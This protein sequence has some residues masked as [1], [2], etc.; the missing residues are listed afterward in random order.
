MHETPFQALSADDRY[1]LLKTAGDSA[2]CPGQLL[3]KD[4]WVVE[5]LRILFEAPFGGDLIFKGGTSLPKA[6]RAIRRFSEDVD[7]MPRAIDTVRLTTVRT[8]G[9][10]G[11]GCSGAFGVR[12]TGEPRQPR[13]A[14]CDVVAFAPNTAPCGAALIDVYSGIMPIQQHSAA[15]GRLGFFAQARRSFGPR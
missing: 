4:I 14:S 9:A 13:P 5:T 10:S 11:A 6:W 7:I 2:R 1:N 3:E 15:R 8:C 12:S